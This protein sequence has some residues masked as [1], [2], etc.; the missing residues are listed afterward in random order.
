MNR[1]ANTVSV[2]LGKGGG[3][4]AAKADYPTGVGP[5]SVALGDL[6]ADGKPDIVTAN[7]SAGTVSVL[8]GRGDGTFATNLDSPTGANALSVVLG[9][10]NRDGKLDLVTANLNIVTTSTTADVSVLLGACK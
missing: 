1:N 2:L 6:D 5:E 8:L 3:T 10:V 4:F 7:S 9:D